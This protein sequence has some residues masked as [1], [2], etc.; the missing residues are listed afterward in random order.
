VAIKMDKEFGKYPV[1]YQHAFDEET[2]KAEVK[3]NRSCGE[4]K[5]AAYELFKVNKIISALKI[6]MLTTS[7]E[8]KGMPR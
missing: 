5:I 3:G 7:V 2:F 8:C 4:I 1:K 6:L